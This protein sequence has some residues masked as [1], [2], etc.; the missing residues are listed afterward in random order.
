MNNYN[1]PNCIKTGKPIADAIICLR[2]DQY[3]KGLC[4]PIENDLYRQTGN[5][6]EL[7]YPIQNIIRK[8]AS[9]LGISTKDVIEIL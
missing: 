7:Y 1:C 6:Y 9:Y 4:S 8:V 3:R 2:C 5:G